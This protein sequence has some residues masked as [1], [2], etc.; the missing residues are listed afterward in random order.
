MQLAAANPKTHIPN[1][2]DAIAYFKLGFRI[3][4]AD[5]F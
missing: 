1:V 3:L 2:L 4:P 5:Q